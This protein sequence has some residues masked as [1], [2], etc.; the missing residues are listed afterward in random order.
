MAAF[1]DIPDYI[2]AKTSAQRLDYFAAPTLDSLMTRTAALYSLWNLSTS[3]RTGASGTASAT[4]STAAA[5]TSSTTGA[6]PFVN[7][8]SGSLWPVEVGAMVS[9]NELATPNDPL[10]HGTLFLCDRLSHQGGLSGTS[11]A[12]QTT[13]LPTAALT[14]YTS[15]TGVFAAL[16]VYANIGTTQTTFTTS[17]TNESGTAARTSLAVTIGG[18][19]SLERGRFFQLPLQ[20]GDTGVR[21]VESVTLL[22]STTTT[23]NIGVALFKPLMMIP[24]QHGQQT[25]HDPFYSLAGAMEE[26]LSNACLFWL[27]I[28]GRSNTGVNSAR[29]STIGINLHL[30]ER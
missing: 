28:G 25:I 20:I 12:A 21:S 18:T 9:G 2:A 26:V 7:P 1:T 30:A 23:G 15:G 5:C 16:E 14:R 17:Y 27:F 10:I 6:S 3:Y 29:I 22:A 13:N 19:G 11:L 8:A 4:P 24:I